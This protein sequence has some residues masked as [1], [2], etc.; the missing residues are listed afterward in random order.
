MEAG[1]PPGRRTGTAGH[2]L[3]ELAAP[4]VI[5]ASFLNLARTKGNKHFRAV[6]RRERVQNAFQNGS[7]HEGAPA[8]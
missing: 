4:T 8:I 6:K 5:S 1:I 3:L 2:I 7:S